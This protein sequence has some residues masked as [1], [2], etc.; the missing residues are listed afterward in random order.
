MQLTR[1]NPLREMQGIDQDFDKLWQNDW[2]MLPTFIEAVALD[3]YEENG[4]LV[5]EVSLPSFK[6]DEVKLT[7]DKGIL[8]ISAEHRE[9][10]EEKGKRRYI[11]RE[12]SN[13]YFRR[14]ALPEGVNGERVDASFKDGILK[15][16]MPMA[17]HKKAKLIT[18]K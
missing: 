6:K 1:Y 16:S 18:I 11:F 14:V 5:A 12:S 4:N 17:V 9:K 3:M 13:Q 7:T 15:V 10:E 8:E 2:A